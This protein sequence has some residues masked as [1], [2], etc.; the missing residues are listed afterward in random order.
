MLDGDFAAAHAIREG[1]HL[2]ARK[3]DTDKC[4]ILAC[5]DAPGNVLAQACAAEPEMP[6]L[7][8]QAGRFALHAAHMEIAITLHGMFGIGARFGD[9]LGF[10]AR[11]L[12]PDQ[13][14]LSGTG[15]RSFLGVSM[16]RET[17]VTPTDFARRIIEAFV[18]H[19]LR[20]RLVR[21]EQPSNHHAQAHEII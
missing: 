13:P 11:A 8:G 17:G 18:S 3:L 14:F 21:V 2:L 19:E 16:P 15:Y 9:W 4:G 20:G 12:H 10:E 7:W 5:D 1:A 6:P